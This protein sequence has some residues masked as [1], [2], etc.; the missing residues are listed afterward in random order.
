MLTWDFPRRDATPPFAGPCVNTDETTAQDTYEALVGF[1]QRFPELASE[2]TLPLPLW[3][4]WGCTHC[5]CIAC[6]SEPAP[7]RH[8]VRGGPT[9]TGCGRVHPAKTS[10][11]HLTCVASFGRPMGL[12]PLF[13]SD[14][15]FFL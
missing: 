1:F 4:E 7:P 6:A 15:V 8:H 9:L 12:F 3:R 13:L 10:V 11:I 5:H 14:S 2:T